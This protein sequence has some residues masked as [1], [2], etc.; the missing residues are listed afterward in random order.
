[1][2]LNR[3][4]ATRLLERLRGKRLTFVGDSLNR[5]QWISM[6]CLLDAVIPS[7]HKSTESTGSLTSFK[8]KVF[9]TN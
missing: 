6:V 4:N 7:P 3:F 8:A 2:K 5:N 9:R 1:M